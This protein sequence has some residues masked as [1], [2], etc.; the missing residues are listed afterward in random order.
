MGEIAGI[1]SAFFW[2][3]SSTLFSEGTRR[4]GAGSVNRIRLIIGLSLFMIVNTVLYGS[5]LPFDAEPRRWLYFGLSGILGLAIGDGLMYTAYNLIGTRRA[6]LVTA[7]SPILSS[8]FAWLILGETLAPLTLAG[9]LLTVLGVGVVVLEGKEIGQGGS[10]R[11][12]YIQGLLASFIA[13]LMYALGTI[14]SKMG[15]SDGFSTVSGVTMRM[16]FANLVAW[17]PVLVTRQTSEMFQ[18]FHEDPKAMR[19]VLIGSM[20]GPFGGVWL[21]FVALQNTSVGIASTL[22]S[23]APIFLLPISRLVYK[24]K[25]SWRAVAGTLVAIA[26]VAVIFLVK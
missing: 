16:V 1:F 20:I 4:F 26:G 13:V 10:H 17:L 9:I 7:F 15:L 3:C 5:P 23:C 11:K 6:M 19:Y 22:T 2:A 12:T 24:E 21:N 8:L 18:K 14:L 25:L